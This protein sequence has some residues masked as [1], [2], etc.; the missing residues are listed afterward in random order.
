MEATWK[1]TII[2]GLVSALTVPF[3][4]NLY[5]WRVNQIE[6]TYGNFNPDATISVDRVTYAEDVNIIR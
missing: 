6:D 1:Q 4:L 2:A 3:F 5:A